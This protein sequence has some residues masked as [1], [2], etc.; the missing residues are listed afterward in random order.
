LTI[1]LIILGLAGLLFGG[2]LLV[3][4]AVT[5]ARRLGV[6]PLVIGLTL[7]GFGTSTPELVTSLQAAFAGSPGVAV[8]NVVG[9]NIA[10]VLLILGATAVIAPVAADP[11]AFR[12]DGLALGAATALGVIAILSGDIGRLFGAILVLGLGG[13]LITVLVMEKRSK[14][15]ERLEDEGETLT[16]APGGVGAGFVFFVIG[17]GLTVLGARFLVSGATDLA[18]SLG[19][20]G[21][22]IC[23]TLCDI[24]TSLP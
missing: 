5:V 11:R 2:E 13:Y 23:R 15:A 6:S 14:E 24:G 8:G 20:S 16:E 17:L 12:R 7:V 22:V 1:L 4:G 21:P 3:R 18:L 9:S 19:I 10:N